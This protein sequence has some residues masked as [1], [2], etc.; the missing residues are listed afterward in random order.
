MATTAFLPPLLWAAAWG[1][2]AVASVAP[3]RVRVPIRIAGWGSSL[4][5]SD[6]AGIDLWCLVVEPEEVSLVGLGCCS[7]MTRHFEHLRILDEGKH[8]REREAGLRG[9]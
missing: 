1:L 7:L 3:S 6:A 9:R 4:S 8:L 5:I 2:A